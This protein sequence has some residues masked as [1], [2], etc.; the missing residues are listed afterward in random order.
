[1]DSRIRWGRLVLAA[2]LLE[3]AITAVALPV[4]MVFGSPMSV[5]PGGPPVDGTVFYVVVALACFLLGAV[6]GYW[7]VARSTSRLALQGLLVGLI[8]MAMYFG[9]CSLAP[10]GLAAV[11]AGYG[12]VMFVMFNALRTLGCVVG[13]M[14]RG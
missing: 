10:G 4:G 8:A 13:A 1:M 11:I 2:F 14:R 12:V 7:A 3:V 9:L 6:F 5:E